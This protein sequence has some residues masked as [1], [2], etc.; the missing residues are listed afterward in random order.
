ML[1]AEIKAVKLALS[2]GRGSAGLLVMTVKLFYFY[3]KK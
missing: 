1:Y 2:L 3:D